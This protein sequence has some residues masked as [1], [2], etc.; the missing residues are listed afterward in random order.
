[1]T[2][3]TGQ[4]HISDVRTSLLTT[5]HFSLL[6]RA[7]GIH[8]CFSDSNDRCKFSPGI[9]FSSISFDWSCH[10]VVVFVIPTILADLIT[11]VLFR[12]SLS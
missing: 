5:V 1:M 6:F 3:K 11:S 8:N 10:W 2:A 7:S 12:D 9:T 4:N